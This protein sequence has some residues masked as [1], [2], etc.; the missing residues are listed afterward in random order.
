MSNDGDLYL[1]ADTASSNVNIT[2][3]S[4]YKIYG[5]GRKVP[6]ARTKKW[7]KVGHGTLSKYE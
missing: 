7:F 2:F 6:I 5:K 4:Q 1:P 3:T